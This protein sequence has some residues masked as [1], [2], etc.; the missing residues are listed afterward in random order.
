VAQPRLL[1]LD[2]PTSQ[3]DPVAGDE[4]L[5]QL[6]R[7]NEEW[8]TSVLLA[9]HRLDRCLAAVDRVLV[10]EGGVLVCDAQP[11]EFVE[12]ASEHAPNMAPPVTRMF[13]LAGV[14]PLP[15]GVKDARRALRT[16][17]L[18]DDPGPP[19]A[20]EEEAPNGG[21]RS[22]WKRAG[23]RLARRGSA[24]E[25]HAL[26]LDG[27]WVE[28]DDGTDAGHAALRGI[29]LRVDPGEKIALLGRNGAG[30]STL[31]RVAAGAVDPARGSVRCRGAVALVLQSPA[32]YFLHE[33]VSDELPAAARERALTELGLEQLADA[34]PRDLSGGERERLALGI[35][36]GG[37]GIGGGS[38]PAV[39]ALD[40]PTLGMDAGRKAALAARLDELA[41][42][43]AAVITA[44][45]DVEFAA[46][47]ARRCVLLG[48]GRV[49]GDGPVRDVLSG[50]RYFST[51]VA[52][53]LGPAARAVL[54][55]QGARHLRARIA[56]TGKVPG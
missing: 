28:F 48:R 9:E 11:A 49:V 40:E 17:R 18:L 24:A 44:T 2:E 29:D 6:R 53:T 34:D 12:W 26:R 14:G 56:M 38:P 33:R 13:S 37:R 47:L 32:D 42:A 39:V 4:L 7:L 30:K 10:L 8:G 46:Q 5:W 31:L 23:G 52:R 35:V 27:I 1:L 25:G 19:F 54:P 21:L 15:V 55:E 20:Q 45:H 51:Q 3:L 36:L 41:R 43:G 22:M 50:G 16:A